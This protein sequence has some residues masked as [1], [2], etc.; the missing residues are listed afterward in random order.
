MALGR[1]CGPKAIDSREENTNGGVKKRDG[2]GGEERKSRSAGK[3]EDKKV[4][5]DR[6]ALILFSA[7]TV[8]NNPLQQQ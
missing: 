1:R 8:W 7:T 3:V 2:D 6:A 5:E 4:R